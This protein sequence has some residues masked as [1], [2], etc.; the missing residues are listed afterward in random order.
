MRII[1]GEHSGRRINL[2]KQLRARP[3]TDQARENLFNI[4]MNKYDMA[5]I[6]VLDLFAGTGSISYEFASLGCPDV[7][8]I[9][10]D[11]FHVAAIQKNCELIGLHS[12]NVVRTDVFRFL[13]KPNRQFDIIFA[14]PPYDL[15]KLA[16]IP[17][18]VLRSGS[19]AQDALFILEHGPANNF[20]EN[21][22]WRETRKYGKVH[23]SFFSI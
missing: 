19:L 3:T 5:N 13:S 16:E 14:D 18:L 7:I 23:F 4:L 11:R 8:S 2:P 1:H 17:N 15:P 10:N 20:T 22:S 21:P 6:R 12:I 9:D